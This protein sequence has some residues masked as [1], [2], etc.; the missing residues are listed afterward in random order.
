VSF[1]AIT[2]CVASQRVVPKISLYFVIAPVRKVLDTPS[3]DGFEIWRLA[4]NIL[5]KQL[6]TADKV[7]SFS[8]VISRRTNLFSSQKNQFVTKCYTVPRT[9]GL[10]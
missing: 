1:A 6:R 8:L 3:Y 5:N 2:L 10:L 7:W 4:A 9:S